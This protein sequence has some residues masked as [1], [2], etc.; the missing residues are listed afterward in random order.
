M[1][2][3]SLRHVACTCSA[4]VLERARVRAHF[5]EVL[6]ELSAR[7]VSHLTDLPRARRAALLAELGRY[8]ITGR[9][10]K[11]R[12]F[13]TQLVP[14][15]I[16]ASGTRCAMAHL[17]ESTGDTDLVAAVASQRNH[18]RIREIETDPTLQSWL[19]RAGLTAAE[20]ARIQPAYCFVTKAEVCLCQRVY[21]TTGVIEATVVATPTTARSTVTVDVVHGNVGIVTVGEQLTIETNYQNAR[22]G[23]HLLVPV[24][25]VQSTLR[26]GG[27]FTVRPDGDVELPCTVNVPGLA[28]AD[29][30][31]ALLVSNGTDGQGAC[32]A[33]LEAV[34][35]VWGESQCAGDGGEGE[36]V[37]DDGGCATTGA[38]ASTPLMIGTALLMAALRT[39][40]S[41][42]V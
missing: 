10:P 7:D 23:D 20:A 31:S 32:T 28:K 2:S 29:A 12:D 35:P 41:S 15:F 34:D 19:A 18:A 16:D 40:R 8:A 21:S 5:R 24:E 42:R 1:T 3:Q 11:N 37:E 4:A 30:I 6:A 22:V 17:I 27:T 9:F 39:R 38:D 26:Y 33:S 25:M 14:I 13:P 36:E